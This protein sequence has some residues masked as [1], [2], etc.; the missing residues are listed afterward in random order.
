MKS[1]L[2]RTLI[3]AC[4][5][6][7]LAAG[8]AELEDETTDEAT[9]EEIAAD[10]PT[11]PAP[12]TQNLFGACLNTDITI[13]NSRTRDGLNTAIEVRSI[14]FFNLTEGKWTSEDL[15]NEILNF[16]ETLVWND[17]DLADAEGDLISTFRVHYRYATGGSWSSQ[18]YQ[19]INTPNQTCIYD[20][21]FSMT[22]E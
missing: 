20:A 15:S 2:N 17:E 22:V 9:P 4:F 3:A 16:G 21:N 13:T 1:F 18:V 19:Q 5:L 8:C 11:S 14:E 10:E 7:P 6:L 12:P